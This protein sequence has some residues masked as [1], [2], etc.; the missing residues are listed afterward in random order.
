MVRSELMGF[1]K[2]TESGKALRVSISVD[3]FNKAEKHRTT[4][5]TEFVAMIINL[6]RIYQVIQGENQVTNISQITD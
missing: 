1:V 6:E 4:D 3:A 2:K 5:G